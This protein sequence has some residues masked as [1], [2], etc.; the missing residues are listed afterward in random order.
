M[1]ARFRNNLVGLTADIE[2]AF[3]MVSIKEEDRNMLR[4]LWFDNPEQDRPKLAQFRFNRLLF[5]L[6]PS[7]SI[8]GAT[9]AHHLSLYK[10]SEP[11]MSALLEKSFYVDDLLSG[12][13]NDEKTLE[14][15]HKSKRI[16]ADGG[17]NL[18]KWNSNSAKVMSEISNSE[19]PRE[20]SIT[21]KKSWSDVTVIE[22]D[23][24]FAKT[25]TGLGS[26]STKDDT[27][28]KVLGLKW[29]TLSDELFFDF[30][31]LHTYATSLPLNKRSVLKVTSKIFD[32]MGFL[33]PFTIG[34]KILFQDLCVDK[35]NWDE[36]LHGKP[37]EKWKSLLDEIRCFETVHIPR[38]YFVATPVEVQIHAFGD[39]SEHAYA[40]VVYLRSCYEDGRIHVRLATSKSKV[41]PMTKQ[42]IPR[43][44]LLGALSLARLVDKFKASIGGNHKTVYWTDSMTTLCWIKNQRIWKQYVQYRVDEI[45]GL[46]S[47]DS[48]RHCPGHS[49][50]ADLPSRGLTAKTL[51]TCETWWKGPEF[52]YLPESEWPENRTTQS[53]DEVALNEVVKSPSTTVHSLVSNS[54]NMPEKKINQI[55]DINRFHD[56][57]NLLRVTALVI[58]TAESFKNAVINKEGTRREHLRLNATDVNEAE[59]LWILTVQRSAFSKEI[60][61]LLSKERSCTPTTYVTQFGLF[62]DEEVIKCKGRLN[63]AP[64]P[65]NT[66]NPILLPAKHEFTR[67]LIKHSHESAKHS[68]IR[69]TLTTLRERYWVLR[70]REAVKGFIRSCVTCLKH[71]GSPYGT[72]PPDDLPSNRAR[73]RRT[74]VR[75]N[76]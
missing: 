6:R 73:L 72:L 2:K 30:S 3:L 76:E 5:G 51:A 46:T 71:E 60:A 49:N 31:S 29:N 1:L 64:L 58:K 48:W 45:R 55:I 4:F 12:T 54:A 24:S 44:E 34:L 35:I 20:D 17:F 53:E 56:L 22:D 38:C 15:Y 39:A 63:N 19:M 43:L 59:R 69:D 68:G 23:Q 70:G 27:V 13:V 75:R 11:E 16:M 52:L 61:F 28:I 50:P 32:P 36:A 18:R 33:T 9:I 57:T 42:S 67:L 26:P 62:L 14:I 21:P 65:V 8:L 74:V 7:P 47:K 10:Q 25:T 66:K 37:L 41:A 40:A